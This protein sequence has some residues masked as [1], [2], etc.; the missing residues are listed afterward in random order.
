MAVK[1]F[2]NGEPASGATSRQN[3]TR[4]R[5]SFMKAAARVAE[6]NLSML[7]MMENWVRSHMAARMY[8]V[9]L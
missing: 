6:S 1:C 3:P 8:L 9:P 2:L 4:S 5:T 7:T